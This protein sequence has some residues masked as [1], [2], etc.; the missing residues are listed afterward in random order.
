M[1]E[2]RKMVKSRP[3]DKVGLLLNLMC[4][5]FWLSPVGIST[6]LGVLTVLN[7]PVDPL[8]LSLANIFSKSECQQ[9][10]DSN[11]YL[12]AFMANA[13]LVSAEIARSF[14]Y[15]LRLL[16]DI[17]YMT[18]LILLKINSLSRENF[19]VGIREYKTLILVQNFGRKAFT[20]TVF[21]TMGMGYCIVVLA[22]SATCRGIFLIPIEIYWL[23][24]TVAVFCV[25]MLIVALPCATFVFNCSLSIKRDWIL[26]LNGLI[27][28]KKFY[29]AHLRSLQPIAFYF[30][31]YRELNNDSKAVYIQSIIERFMNGLLL[32]E[33]S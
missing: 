14:S 4:L 19:S 8:Y 21:L 26:R 1:E 5:V 18:K 15:S 30:G 7:F 13:Y 29:R 3:F 24:P 31:S 9:I 2:L 27:R 25:I 12:I 17:S 22:L 10:I 28:R 20:F 33:A 6:F 32:L 11:V 16:I 23:F